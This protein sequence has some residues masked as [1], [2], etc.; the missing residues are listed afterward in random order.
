MADITSW[1]LVAMYVV[2]T[3]ALAML[4]VAVVQIHRRSRRTR[5]WMVVA[6]IALFLVGTIDWPVTEVT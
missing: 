6:T 2:L 1:L 5:G 3:I 4:G